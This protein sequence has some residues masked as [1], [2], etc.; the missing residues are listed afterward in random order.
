MR[1]F[2][3]FSRNEGPGLWAEVPSGPG[4]T[5]RDSGCHLLV[6]QKDRADWMEMVLPSAPRW[7]FL[8]DVV[9]FLGDIP[10]FVKEGWDKSSKTLDLAEVAEP[11]QNPGELLGQRGQA[12]YNSWRLSCS[13]LVPLIHHEKC[14]PAALMWGWTR[15]WSALVLGTRGRVSWGGWADSSQTESSFC[16]QTLGLRTLAPWPLGADDQSRGIKTFIGVEGNTLGWC[17][18]GDT[19]VEITHRL[20]QGGSTAP[21]PEMGWLGRS[22]GGVP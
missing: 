13:I 12:V 14:R 4:W 9:T 10:D 18:F 5:N 3:S 20:L 6:F 21:S 7:C 17:D 22:C 11:G 8:W 15:C 16:H 19:S 2:V 1:V